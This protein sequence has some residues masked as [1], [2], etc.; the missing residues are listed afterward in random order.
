[1]EDFDAVAERLYGLTP[2]QFTAARNAAA[3]QARHG[4]DRALADRIHRLRRPTQGAWL[5]NLLTRTDPVGVQRLLDLGH[6]LREAQERLEGK[7]MREL[8]T[9][10]HRLAG[11]LV[12]AAR[13]A[14]T[15]RGHSTGQSALAELE[16]TLLA[17]TGSQAA[18][19]ALAASRLTEALPPATIADT[20][21]A[22]ALPN[23]PAA[24]AAPAPAHRAR[25]ASQRI[26]DRPR[27]APPT[28]SSPAPDR[29]DLANRRWAERLNQASDVAVRAERDSSWPGRACAPPWRHWPVRPQP[30]SRRI[31]DQTGSGNGNCGTQ[32]ASIPGARPPRRPSVTSSRRSTART[33]SR[34]CARYGRPALPC[35][36]ARSSRWSCCARWWC[37][38]TT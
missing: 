7:R 35:G 11:Q 24:P 33:P 28:R 9:Q 17:A 37:R 1:M 5:A 27:S 2:N 16:Q 19:D 6:A 10:R 23:R 22:L 32:P 26:D 21:T 31:S 14:A 38:P 12:D 8:T 3:E 20:L 25:P 34:C 15:A 13:T 4:G 18:A 36:C 30:D 29:T